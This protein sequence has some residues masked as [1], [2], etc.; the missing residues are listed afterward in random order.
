MGE[1]FM[2][3]PQ[4][5]T[6]SRTLSTTTN[7]AVFPFTFAS[8][9]IAHQ[10]HPQRNED[11]TMLDRRRGLAA[12]F[13][14]VG[15]ANAGE[16]ASQLGARTIRRA[17]KRIMQH[18][19]LD[20][21]SVLPL[22]S[23]DID[24]QALLQQAIQEAHEVISNEG[25]R[26]LKL[27][28]IQAGKDTYP[29][30]TAVVTALSQHPTRKYYRMTYAHVGDSR[31][32]LLRSGG[33][34]QRLTLDDGYFMLKIQDQ[35]LT[36]EDAL[37]IDQAIHPAHLSE[38]ERDIFSKRNGITQCL[39]HFTPSNSSLTIHTAQVDIFPGDR[40]LL[41]SDGIHDN[42]TDD[43]IE[44]LIRNKACTTVAHHLVQHALRRSRELC[45]RA[46]HDD[47]SAVVISCNF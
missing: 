25:D 12:V 24:V 6:D 39:G 9:S 41:C 46:K 7:K 1:I 21:T 18:H 31:I 36:M 17:W 3:M 11:T 15:G 19:L 44:T 22:L 10:G 5:K 30:T 28:A 4:T 27:A 29:E 43:E 34:L 33:R 2:H 32:Y 38:I 40:I 20:T 35:T 45:L 42:L 37:R 13:D 16:V 14:G 23:D 47:M 26:R 8:R